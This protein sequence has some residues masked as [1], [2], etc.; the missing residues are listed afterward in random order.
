MFTSPYWP[1]RKAEGRVS[2]S[3]SSQGSSFFAEGRYV[4][5]LVS[6]LFGINGTKGDLAQ[7]RLKQQWDS[8]CLCCRE[9][10]L[11]LSTNRPSQ[12]ELHLSQKEYQMFET[13]GPI[14]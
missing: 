3:S 6:K 1:M 2:H 9:I 8:R 11:R 7:A 12:K 14:R 13:P 5:R 4:R 10:P